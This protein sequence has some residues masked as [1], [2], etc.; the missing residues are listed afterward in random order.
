M[1]GNQVKVRWAK[2]ADKYL[3][4]RK[5]IGTRYLT[6]EEVEGL[7]WYNSAIVLILDDG[8]LIFPSCDDE[9]NNAGAIF[10]QFKNGK[11]ITIPVI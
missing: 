2:E 3:L 4:G 7:G 5:I 9:G 8:T 1:S 11:E 10:G 6:D